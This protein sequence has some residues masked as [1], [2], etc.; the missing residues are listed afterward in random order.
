MPIRRNYFIILALLASLL[1][2]AAE[3]YL[4]SRSYREAVDAAKQRNANIAKI[5]AERLS[6]A[7]REIDYIMLDVHDDVCRMMP[8]LARGPRQR[9]TRRINGILERKIKTHPWIFG[10]GVMNQKGIFVAGVD[11]EGPVKGSVGADRSFREYYSYLAT[12]PDEEVHCSGAFQEMNTK[13]IWFAYSRVVRANGRRRLLGVIYAGLYAKNMASLFGEGGFAKSGAVAVV[14]GVGKLLLHIPQV[15]KADGQRAAYPELD[16]F[17][18]SVQGRFE[19]IT[20]S[21]WDGQRCISAFHRVDDLP[22][23]IVVSSALSEDLGPWRS[24]LRYHAA[25]ILSIILLLM[26]TALL[27]GRLLKAKNMLEVQA[28]EL[29]HQAKTDVLTGISNRRH[30]FEMAEREMMRARRSEKP[31]ALLM[32]DIDHFKKINDKCGHSAGDEVLK[33]LSLTSQGTIRNIDVFGRI[34]GE[35]FAIVLPETNLKQATTVA[36]RLRDKLSETNLKVTGSE[37]VPFTVSIGVSVLNDEDADIDSLLKRADTAM[38][39]AK[40]Y[41]RNRVCSTSD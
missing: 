37:R 32:I 21:P 19:G 27:A 15:P 28:I 12:H 24:Q 35:E 3:A 34:G 9:E 20:V 25:G 22:Y 23:T 26:G 38:Y 17:L 14:D 16:M 5:S 7:L 31:M 29:E 36:E 4:L 11:R 8:S 39:Q 33:C 18:P 2:V 6:G 30:F 41:G 10:F 40:R 13:D 1:L